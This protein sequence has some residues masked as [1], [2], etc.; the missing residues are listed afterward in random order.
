MLTTVRRIQEDSLN[1]DLKQCFL[2][3]LLVLKYRSL[4]CSM[5]GPEK[6]D[7]KV[8]NVPQ[9]RYEDRPKSLFENCSSNLPKNTSCKQ[10][11]MST[12]FTVRVFCIMLH[13]EKTFV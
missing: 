7:V 5:V 4:I 3:S 10:T 2:R 9:K 1:V 8:L 13:S 6:K 11:Q 12:V